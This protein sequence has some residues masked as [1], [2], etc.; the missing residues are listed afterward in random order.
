MDVWE[1]TLLASISYQGRALS[2][3]LNYKATPS[4]TPVGVLALGLSQHT[5]S[6]CNTYK[7]W[8]HEIYQEIHVAL[9]RPL[10]YEALG[11]TFEY[12]CGCG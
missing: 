3:H 10:T 6:V 12:A 1:R 11:Q 8:L 4:N 2:P 5:N 7:V 9:T